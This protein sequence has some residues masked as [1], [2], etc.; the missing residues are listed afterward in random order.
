[1]E[2]VP[3]DDV[4]ERLFSAVEQSNVDTVAQLLAQ[5]S[6]LTH[7]DINFKRAPLYQTVLHVACLNNSHQIALQLLD[8][9]ADINALDLQDYTPLHYASNF[10]HKALALALIDRGADTSLKDV[11]HQRI[12]QASQGWLR[13]VGSMIAHCDC[14]CCAM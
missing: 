9:G 10:G 1:M 4:H 7:I 6:A 5:P 11:C 12:Y 14:V 2:R 3:E 8:W 13:T